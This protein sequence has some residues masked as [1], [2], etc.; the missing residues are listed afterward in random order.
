MSLLENAA[1]VWKEFGAALNMKGMCIQLPGKGRIMHE[2]D[3]NCFVPRSG[4]NV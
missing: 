4:I 3:L 2:S 1:Q